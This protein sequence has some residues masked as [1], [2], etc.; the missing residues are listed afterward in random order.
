MTDQEARDEAVPNARHITTDPACQFHRP[1]RNWWQRHR[2]DRMRGRAC[3]GCMTWRARVSHLMMR[4]FT[5]GEAVALVT[6]E[7]A[8]R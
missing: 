5:R 2:F 8:Y 1:P 7:S 4:G 6:I 3:I